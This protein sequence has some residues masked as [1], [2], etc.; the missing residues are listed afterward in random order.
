MIDTAISFVTSQPVGIFSLLFLNNLLMYMALNR[1][2]KR[3]TQTLVESQDSAL[4]S[5]YATNATLRSIV[6]AFSDDKNGIP[7]EAVKAFD[8]PHSHRHGGK[9]YLKEEHVH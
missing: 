4:A 7:L 9:C 3:E 6:Y 2:H 5:E 1:K 8:C